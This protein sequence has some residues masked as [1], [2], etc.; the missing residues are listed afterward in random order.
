VVCFR[1][2]PNANGQ[3]NDWS[4][5]ISSLLSLVERSCH[6]ISLEETKPLM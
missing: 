5:D 3:L 1:P 4:A 6:L 2:T